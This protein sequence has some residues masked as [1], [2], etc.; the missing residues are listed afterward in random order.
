[1]YVQNATAWLWDCPHH[2]SP[3]HIAEQC[4]DKIPVRYL[5]T[6]MYVDPITH[7]T[8]TFEYAIKILCENNSEN[9]IVLDP[10]TDQHYVLTPQPIKK[11][12]FPSL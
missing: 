9:V 10:G 5:D 12:P 1:M 6:V 4:Y 2:L 8:Q 11:R 7:R 3:L